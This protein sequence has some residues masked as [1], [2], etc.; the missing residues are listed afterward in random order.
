M[1][2]AAPL[3]VEYALTSSQAVK[4]I[5]AFVVLTT[6]ILRVIVIVTHAL[7]PSLFFLRD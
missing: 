1:K 5:V 6:S 7:E 3:P 2:R 4:A